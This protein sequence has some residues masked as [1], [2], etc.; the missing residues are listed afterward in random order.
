MLRSIYEQILAAFRT[1]GRGKPQRRARPRR[2]A[3]ESLESRKLMTVTTLT[4]NAVSD[5]SFEAPAL[6]SQAYVV[7]PAST[8]WQFT[9]ISGVSRNQSAFTAGDPNAPNGAQVAFIQDNASISQTVDLDAGVYTLSML[10]AE[11]INYQTQPQAV[12]VLVDG[13]EVGLITPN[14]PV[15][16]NNVTYTTAYTTYET[17]NFTVTAGLHTVELLGTSQPS[18]GSTNSVDSTAFIDDVTLTPAVDTIVNGGFETPAL[19]PNGF[20]T[21]PGD[22]G[23]QFSG[24]AGIA[25]NGSPFLT[26]WTEAQNAPTGAQ[27]GYIEYTGSMSQ[28]VYL[29]AGTYQLSCLAAQRDIYQASYQEIEIKVDGAEVGTVNPVNNLY[30]FYTSSTFTVTTGPH[31][32][33]FVGLDPQGGDNTAFIDQVTLSANI[34]NDGSFE[35]PSIPAGTYQFAPANSPWQF[36]A[37]AGVAQNGSSYSANSNAPDGAQ[38]AVIKGTGSMSQSINLIAGEYNV[39]FLAA[40]RADGQPQHQEIEVLFDGAEVGLITPLD[41]N[42]RLYESS[43]FTVS[44]AEAAGTNTI[45]LLG[46]NPKGGDNTALI[47]ELVVAP[48]QDEIFDG[49]FETPVLAGNT[50][51]VAPGATAWQFS[52]S[53]GISTNGSGLTSGTANAPQGAQVGFLMNN[54][55]VSQSVYLDAETYDISFMAAQRNTNQSLSQTVEVLV[56]GTPVALV[57]PSVTSTNY[58]PSA[59]TLFQTSTFTVAAGV[60]TIEFLGMTPANGNSTAFIDS[61]TLST[62]ENTFAGGNFDAPVQ[63]IDGYTIAPAGSAWQYSGVAGVTADNSGFTYISSKATANVPD[64][65]QDAF[66]KNNGSISQTVYFDAGTYNISFLASQRI[67]YQTQAQEI[68]VLVDGTSVAMITPAV[69]TTFNST[70]SNTTYVYTPYQTSNFTVAAGPHTV[71]FLGM[72]QPVNNSVDSTAFIADTVINLGSAARRRQLRGTGPGGGDLR[73]SARRRGLAIHR[74]RRNKQQSQR[75]S[76]GAIRLPPTAISSP[77]SRT[78]AA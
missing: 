35:E 52:G 8:P 13:A 49:G 24:T 70:P 38:V 59:Y 43:N 69:A 17:P 18:A 26:N 23:W 19:V 47:D 5:G 34:V 14:S 53:A 39:N 41:A 30:G 48:A 66:I 58:F 36:T 73:G 3:M 4:V 1:N 10:A 77:S 68:D 33:A 31:T 51:Q 74:S 2:L 71:K 63:A 28:T 55:T 57:T 12:E 9:G 16:A 44:A 15:T 20:A 32:I 40:Q 61:V 7:A 65:T 78:P 64:G 50:Y 76:P 42:Y 25:R 6:P 45:E 37:T 60:H 29:D 27:V 11:R 54:G 75:A 46:V 56:D 21:D 62:L 22:A 67:A 72:V